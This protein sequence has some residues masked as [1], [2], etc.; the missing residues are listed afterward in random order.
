MKENDFKTLFQ[1]F[2]GN[3]IKHNPEKYYF[4]LNR[5]KNISLTVENGKIDT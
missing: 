4:L 1:W 2:S 3:R 5:T